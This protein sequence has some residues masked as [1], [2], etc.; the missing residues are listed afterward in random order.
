[1]LS[2]IPS[3]AIVA[4]DLPVPRRVPINAAGLVAQR[5]GAWHE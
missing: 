3:P 5:A 4:E 1:M 2:K